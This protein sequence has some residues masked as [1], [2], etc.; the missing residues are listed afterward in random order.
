[1]EGVQEK[2]SRGSYSRGDRG[3][4]LKAFDLR[5]VRPG[6]E[7]N[8]WEL[9]VLHALLPFCYQ[10]KLHYGTSKR[11]KDPIRSGKKT[12]TFYFSDASAQPTTY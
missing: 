5:F 8:A 7:E 12:E 9:K 1:L 10:L 6:D 3:I 2:S 4:L 11:C